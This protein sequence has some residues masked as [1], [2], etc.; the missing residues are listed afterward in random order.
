MELRILGSNTK[1]LNR[2]LSNEKVDKKTKRLQVIEIFEDKKKPL[3]AKEVAVEMFKRG[4]ASS[5]D[6]NNSHP[7]I[8]ELEKMDILE[9][10]GSKECEYT[11]HTVSL[12]ALR[13]KTN[14][15]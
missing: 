1:I 8:F 7:R 2:R 12:Y 15:L 11:H 3:S 13:K 6:R 4:Y 5:D 14:G 9:N 10:V